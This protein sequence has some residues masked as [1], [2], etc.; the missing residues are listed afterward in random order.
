MDK[1]LAG[2]LGAVAGLATMSAAQAA[3]HPAPSPAEAL[4]ASS[5]AD[6]LT[7]I[8]NAAALLKADAASARQ[9][10]EM[11]LAQVYYTP[12]PPPYAYYHHHHHHHHRYWRRYSHHHHHHHHHHGV[13]VGI[14]GIGGVVVR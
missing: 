7:P 12:Y 11:Q 4:Q 8:P 1:K 10:A 14:P 13:V 3:T 5:Y 9:P 2:L 6:L